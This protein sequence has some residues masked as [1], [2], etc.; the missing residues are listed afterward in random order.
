MA[1]G[2]WTA[3]NGKVEP[4]TADELA[5]YDAVACAGDRAARVVHLYEVFNYV[6]MSG[7][8]DEDVRVVEASELTKRYAGIVRAFQSHDDRHERGW[9][10]PALEELF[11][12]T[13]SAKVKDGANRFTMKLFREKEWPI[14]EANVKRAAS[15]CMAY[16]RRE[17]GTGVLGQRKILNSTMLLFDSEYQ[18]ILKAL[19]IL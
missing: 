12:R 6:R 8:K 11:D 2:D 9:D 1:M 18:S 19:E 16:Q 4:M 5:A 15:A 7:S 3:W 17:S 14:I 10:L 13:P